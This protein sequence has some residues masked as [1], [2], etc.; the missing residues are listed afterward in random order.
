MQ[1][2]RKTNGHPD[3]GTPSS[4]FRNLSQQAIVFNHVHQ[5]MKAVAGL[6]SLATKLA[7]RYWLWECMPEDL[8]AIE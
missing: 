5:A 3:I 8:S 6:V 7:A 2:S 1:V 4:T